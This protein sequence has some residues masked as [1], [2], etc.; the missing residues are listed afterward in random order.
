[1]AHTQGLAAGH[2]MWAARREARGRSLTFSSV[3]SRSFLRNESTQSLK[4]RS[5]RLLYMRR[6][7][8]RVGAPVS[9]LRAPMDI[10]ARGASPVANL[11][12]LDSRCQLVL[13]L[14]RQLPYCL[15]V[16]VHR[17]G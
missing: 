8:G 3:P 4:H 1:M 17:S 13:L 6:L 9:W 16:G 10:A 15:Q 11:H 7:R 5:T 14:L 2:A 12:S